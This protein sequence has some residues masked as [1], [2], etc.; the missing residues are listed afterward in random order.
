MWLTG[1]TNTLVVGL[2]G[3]IFGW[4]TYLVARGLFTRKI[5][6]V[7]VG[8]AL[9]VVYGGMLWGVFPGDPGISWQAHLWGAVGG[10]IAAVWLGRRSR[11]AVRSRKS[12]EVG[13]IAS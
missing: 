12:S 5:V 13:S 6:D 3:V 10:V 1:G 2:S 4:M 8:L 9:L 7:V 11:A